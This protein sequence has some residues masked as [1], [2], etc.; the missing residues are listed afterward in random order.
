[1]LDSQSWESFIWAAVSPGTTVSC[2]LTCG[3]FQ[4]ANLSKGD[5][6]YLDDAMC[7]EPSSPE[8]AEE[9]SSVNDVLPVPTSW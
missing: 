4:R 6:A 5:N 3:T 8:A 1:M 2:T 9:V 7:S